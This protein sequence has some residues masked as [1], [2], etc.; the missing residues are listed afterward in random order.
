MKLQDNNGAWFKVRCP[1]C[2]S[3]DLRYVAGSLIECRHCGIGH[4]GREY[5]QWKSDKDKPTTSP[6]A[7][8]RRYSIQRRGKNKTLQKLISTTLVAKTA[9]LMLSGK[10]PDLR[11]LDREYSHIDEK[12]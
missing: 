11:S 5:H 4:L 12:I 6:F 8:D 1:E 7:N 9:I 10:M 2:G 3:D